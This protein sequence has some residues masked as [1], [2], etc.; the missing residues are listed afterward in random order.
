MFKPTSKPDPH[1]G[2]R[3]PDQEIGYSFTLPGPD[4][5]MGTVIFG[6]IANGAGSKVMLTS[7]G[8]MRGRVVTNSLMKHVLEKFMEKD[9]TISP[10]WRTGH[11]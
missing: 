6:A 1:D 11:R 5:A 2:S 8:N 7:T 3:Q 10:D 4:P 9:P